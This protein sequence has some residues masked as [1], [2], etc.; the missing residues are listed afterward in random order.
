MSTVYHGL[1]GGDSGELIMAAYTLGVAHPP[2]YPL[3][4]IITKIALYWFP[5]SPP[6]YTA[7]VL[8]ACLGALAAGVLGEATTRLDKGDRWAGLIAGGTFG[9]SRLVWQ[10]STHAEVRASYEIESRNPKPEPEPEPKH[11][12]LEVFSLNN[13][14]LACL[15]HRYLSYMSEPRLRTA[16]Q[17]RTTSTQTNLSLLKP[18]VESLS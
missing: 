3:W 18:C 7:N 12:E 16:S 8:T 15:L 10:Y 17:G 2:G 14:L 9:C 13:L 5:S 4:T 6:A 11:P 1:A